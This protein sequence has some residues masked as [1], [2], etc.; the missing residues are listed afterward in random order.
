[1]AADPLASVLQELAAARK[2]V[3]RSSGRQIRNREDRDLLSATA[4][5]WFQSHRQQITADQELIEPVNTAY[6]TILDATDRN[7]TK[8][9]YLQAMTAAKD[10]L[11]AL[12]GHILLASRNPTVE[13]PPN[14]SPLVGDPVMRGILE[15][16]W[17]EC[18]KCLGLGA[19]LAAIV[20]MGGLLE[21]LFVARANVMTNKGALFKCKATPQDPK[22]KKPT[23]LRDWTLGPYIDVGHEIGWITRSAKDVAA[24]LRDYRNYIHPEKERSHGI[25]LNPHDSAM[26]W[27]VTKNLARQVLASA[28]NP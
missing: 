16:R 15:R 26:L 11:V 19:D 9:A 3:S 6:H 25:V 22:T 14:F 20:M 2:R 23:D 7:T 4:Y 17:N 18:Q 1:M 5:A 24:V 21:A 13:A 8:A 28:S 12:R 10:A 27:D